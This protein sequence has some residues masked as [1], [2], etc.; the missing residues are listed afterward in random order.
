[1]SVSNFTTG[2]RVKIIQGCEDGEDDHLVGKVGTIKD[3]DEDGYY[4]VALD[5]ENS[6]TFQFADYQMEKLV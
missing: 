3:F 2:N 6:D 5:G 4:E 1:M